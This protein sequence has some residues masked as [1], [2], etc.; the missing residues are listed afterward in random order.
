[1]KTIEVHVHTRDGE[2][3]RVITVIENATVED[4]L[5]LV[6]PGQHE[7]LWLVVGDEDQARRRDERLND[8][9]V[10]HQ[11]HVHCHSKAIHYAVDG[12]SQQTRKHKL[13]AVEIMCLASVDPAKHYLIRLKPHGGEESYKDRPE[14]C[15]HMHDGMRFI[16]ASLCPTP[17][18]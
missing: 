5:R 10:G 13:T 3:P 4:L 2:E 6:S 17:V 7:D 15:I 14:T 1:M 9:G 11:Q 8:C 12:E 18:S 16:T